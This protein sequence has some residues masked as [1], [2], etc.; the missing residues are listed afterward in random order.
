MAIDRSEVVSTL[1]DLIETARDG[2]QGFR[3]SADNA[4]SPELKS[5]FLE[6]ASRCQKAVTEL[7]QYVSQYGGTP[8]T[9][10]TVAGA[11]HRGWVNLKAAL[12]LNDD[13]AVLNEVERGED[14]AVTVYRNALSKDLPPEIKS[15]VQRMYEG[16]EQNHA[17]VRAL[18]D[19]YTGGQSGTTTG[20]TSL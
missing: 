7:Q 3:S 4:K 14:H 2:E 9:T 12:A 5:F 6:G 8:E 19:Q 11:V 18:R 17:R 20:T 1:N 13:K 10:G 15:V 16:T